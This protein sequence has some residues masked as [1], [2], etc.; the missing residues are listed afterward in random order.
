MLELLRI[1]SDPYEPESWRPQCDR[2]E[3]RT[4]FRFYLTSARVP[5]HAGDGPVLAW[6]AGSLF[7]HQ[8]PTLGSCWVSEAPRDFTA[9]L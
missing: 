4:H 3:T 1:L 2:T 7:D 6:E 5:R 8:R 9:F